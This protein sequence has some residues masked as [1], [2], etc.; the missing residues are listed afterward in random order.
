M[1]EKC[2]IMDMSSIVVLF[3]DGL[4]CILMLSLYCAGMY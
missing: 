2:Y 3:N 1:D 4:T